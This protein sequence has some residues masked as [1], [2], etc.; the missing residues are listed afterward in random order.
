MIM[1]MAY[2]ASNLM[3][4]I[5]T[6][7]VQELE[8]NELS[9]KAFCYRPAPMKDFIKLALTKNPKKRPSADKL[10]QVIEFIK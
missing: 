4:I 6:I 7:L 10:L 1:S 8:E 3:N 5:A 2:S 9:I